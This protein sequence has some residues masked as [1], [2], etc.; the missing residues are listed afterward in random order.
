MPHRRRHPHLA[1]CLHQLHWFLSLQTVLVRALLG[2]NARIAQTLML[3]GPKCDHLMSSAIRQFSPQCCNIPLGACVAL[4]ALLLK[5]VRWA[6]GQGASIA[7]GGATG[8]A[9]DAAGAAVL[10][11]LFYLRD[12]SCANPN[13]AG[14]HVHAL[15]A[16]HQRLRPRA[17]RAAVPPRA[18]RC[19]HGLQVHSRCIGRGLAQA[20][21]RAAAVA[22]ADP[23]CISL[24]GRRRWKRQGGGGLTSYACPCGSKGCQASAL[25]IQEFC[26]GQLACRRQGV[27]LGTLPRSCMHRNIWL[28]G[29]RRCF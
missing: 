9:G 19:L 14:V 18:A 16:L 4:T 27:S 7:V 26:F 22:A 13:A 20:Q 21:Q 28:A 1:L 25:S 8:Q 10:T 24:R 15:A 23:G 12:V 6:A 11:P 29:G 5:R 3:F 17:V 2:F